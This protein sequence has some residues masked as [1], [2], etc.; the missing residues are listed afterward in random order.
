MKGC[1]L[2]VC[3]AVAANLL[4]APLVFTQA[5]AK[6]ALD[7]ALGLVRACTPRNAGT[8]E[9]LK[10]ARWL[11]EALV[12]KGVPA[13][14]EMF[15]AS[16]P[17]GRKTFANV[18]AERRSEDS[19]APW[20]VVLSHF[21]TAPNVDPSFEGANDGASTSGLLLALAVS[22]QRAK[23]SAVN[24][25]F[26]WTDGEECMQ[27]Y[28]PNDG[29]QGSRHL[30]RRFVKE[31]RV[32]KAAVCLDMLGDRDLGIVLPANTTESLAEA[33]FEAARRTGLEAKLSQDKSIVISDDHTPFLASG[34]PAID[35]IDFSFGSKPG[36]NDYWHTK[37]D[38]MDKISE[39]S[40]Y[41][42]GRLVCAFFH[43]LN[44]PK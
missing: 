21:D 41:E 10:A 44:N 6:V 2:G 13:H 39:R 37:Q 18:V 8:L 19:K 40:L 12:A 28:G 33:A 34:Y 20:I 43:V 3:M 31:G 22:V 25:M 4:A 15:T 7:T 32:V 5:D 1:V 35:F 11:R 38:T 16:T 24:W 23:N 42:A 14:L 9:G 29:F 30:A 36:A 26:V 17:L 27:N